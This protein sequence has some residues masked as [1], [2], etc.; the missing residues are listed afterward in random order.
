M[1][2]QDRHEE[3]LRA[4]LQRYGIE[5]EW[6]TELVDF[7]QDDSK[8]HLILRYLGSLYETYCERRLSGSASDMPNL[9]PGAHPPS[10]AIPSLLQSSDTFSQS[11]H[12]FP[13]LSGS[14][15]PI[16]TPALPDVP[17]DALGRVPHSVIA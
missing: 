11:S 14:T 12:A 8:V 2:G 7:T 13:S 1:L 16:P 15:E 4:H 17:G 9:I 5:V 6:A 10:P 3:I